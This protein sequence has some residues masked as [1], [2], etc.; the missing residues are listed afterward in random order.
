MEEAELTVKQIL[1][2]SQ[3][4]VRSAKT[5]DPRR[6]R[7]AARLPASHRGLERV[8]LR[9]PRGDEGPPTA[10]LREDRRRA[11]R[12]RTRPRWTEPRTSGRVAVRFR[13]QGACGLRSREVRGARR[14]ALGEHATVRDGH[15][16]IAPGPA[17]RDRHPASRQADPRAARGTGCRSSSSRRRRAGRSRPEGGADFA[18]SP[19]PGSAVSR[20]APGFAHV[21]E[22]V[23]TP[24]PPPARSRAHRGGPALRG[25]AAPR[26]P[27][28]RLQIRLARGERQTRGSADLTRSDGRA[29]G[30]HAGHCPLDD[31]A[32]RL[33]PPQRRSRSG[34]RA[35]APARRR[36]GTPRV[37]QARPPAGRRSRSATPRIESQAMS[38][39]GS[40]PVARPVDR[41]ASTPPATR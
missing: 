2:N 34:R 41:R 15:E 11:R 37:P 29:P 24:P 27:H 20:G 36:R 32:D 38:S 33:Q 17:D 23:R 28:C 13:E 12:A 30:G 21:G 6:D 25:P 40:P 3:A 16:P 5:D 4:A 19:L 7:P 8:H 22:H 31:P 35:A 26:D 39:A 9:R 10:L 18:A 14:H 1:R